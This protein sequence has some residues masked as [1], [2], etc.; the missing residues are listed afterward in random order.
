SHARHVDG[1]RAKRQPGSA[2]KPLLYGLALDLRLLTPASLIEDTPLEIAVPDGLYRP[3]N[4]DEHFRGPVTLR[5]ALAA[6]LNVPAVR[7]LQLVGTETFVQQ[8]KRLGFAGMV[9]RGDYY[10]PALEVG[11]A[12]VSL[13]EL[14]NAYRTLANGGMWS[15]LRLTPDEPAASATRVYSE[16]AT[17]LISNILSDRASRS[18]TFGLDNPLATRFWSAV[19]TGTSKD[20]RDNWCVGYSRRYT[21]GVWVG[22]FSGQPM[23]DVSGVTGAAPIWLEVMSWLPR[24]TASPPPDPPAGVEAATVAPPRAVGPPRV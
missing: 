2:L 24:E 14:T 3:Q 20:M 6:S 16:P 18:P 12:D 9:E 4:Y 23:A 13:W 11:S 7:T 19:K 10:G 8:L 22:N 5:T 1:V 15:S 17:F 21:V